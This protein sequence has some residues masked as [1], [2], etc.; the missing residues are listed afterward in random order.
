[1]SDKKIKITKATRFDYTIES[2]QDEEIKIVENPAYYREYDENGNLTEETIYGPGGYISEKYSFV[3]NNGKVAEQKTWLDETTVA[4]HQ[5][6]EYE[7]DKLVKI[8]TKYEEGYSDETRLEYDDKGRLVSKI[9]F[10][11]GE[12]G[13]KQLTE[14]NGN[15]QTTIKYD[16]YGNK[17]SEETTETDD[18]G[19]VTYRKIIDFNEETEEETRYEYDS[20]GKITGEEHSGN[21][22]GAG[23]TVENFYD[24]KG[25]LIKT[26]T[27]TTDGNQTILEIGY[28]ENGNEI[29]QV[30]KN[31]AGELNHT[32]KRN[33]DENGNVVDTE[34][35]I[36]NHGY[37]MD[38]HYVIKYEYVYY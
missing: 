1:M 33:Y 6:F 31:D 19:N 22:E 24:E 16:E 7:G 21:Y 20:S 12:E 5:F 11:D 28:D 8:I 36:F 2:F 15:G 18:K 29:T 3:Y 14:Y 37:D 25:R 9:T 17:E 26:I 27:K 4:E 10:D 34:V 30:E 23:R 35:E 38:Q 32:V 13:E